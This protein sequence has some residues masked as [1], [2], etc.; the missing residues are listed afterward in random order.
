MK[1]LIYISAAKQNNS[2]ALGDDPRVANL[3]SQIKKEISKAIEAVYN[4]ER[5]GKSILLDALNR[6]EAQLESEYSD[7]KS[8]FNIEQ[9]VVLSSNDST[10]LD[11]YMLF[12]DDKV[13]ELKDQLKILNTLLH[14]SVYAHSD[15][16]D[17]IYSKVALI[18]DYL[19]PFND[20]VYY[21]NKDTLSHPSLEQ[22]APILLT[23]QCKKDTY[24]VNMKWDYR[25][26]AHGF[27][28][29]NQFV[30]NTYKST[31]IDPDIVQDILTTVDTVN[32]NTSSQLY[33]ACLHDIEEL[34]SEENYR[35]CKELKNICVSIDEDDTRFSKRTNWNT[36]K[37]TLENSTYADPIY[38]GEDGGDILEDMIDNAAA[39]LDITIE[40]SIQNGKGSQIFYDDN[41]NELGECDYTDFNCDVVDIALDS[42]SKNECQSEIKKY[43]KSL[44]GD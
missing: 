35:M 30:R 19:C 32:R 7:I 15:L 10:S 21:S 1:K 36:I 16:S 40:P 6:T 42:S 14:T 44:L 4:I 29:A 12:P 2:M 25:R 20:K 43:I 18:Q 17:L 11:D 33:K 8:Q 31:G 26:Y 41:D 37:Q 13:K 28:S 39:S 38:E 22:N 9:F 23:L 24:N 27:I 34:S 5:T 3:V